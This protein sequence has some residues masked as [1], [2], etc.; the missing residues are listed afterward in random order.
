MSIL[1]FMPRG[2]N[3]VTPLA[4]F[5]LFIILYLLASFMVLHGILLEF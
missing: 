4:R 2:R 3:L 5:L 1:F